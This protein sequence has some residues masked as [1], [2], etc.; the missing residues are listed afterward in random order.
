MG[1]RAT[2]TLMEKHKHQRH[3]EPLIGELVKVASALALQQAMGF[4][5]S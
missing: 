4:E 1:Q 2:D 3:F 5:F